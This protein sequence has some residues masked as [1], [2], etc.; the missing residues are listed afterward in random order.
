MA[1]SEDGASSQGSD[2]D[3]RD[4][5]D[6]AWGDEDDDEAGDVEAAEEALS[7]NDLYPSGATLLKAACCDQYI[8]SRPATSPG[9]RL[10]AG[11][12]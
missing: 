9:S 4:A 5:F 1:G 6:D 3:L 11:P 7:V 8:L 10:V 2:A 12:W